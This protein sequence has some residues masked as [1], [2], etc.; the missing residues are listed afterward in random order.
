MTRYAQ[1]ISP[2]KTPQVEQAHE[3]QVENNAG[4]YSFTLDKWS[5]LDRFLILGAEGGTYYVNERKH[6]KDNYASLKECLA[7]NGPKT[8]DKIVEISV[9]GRA[10]KNDPAI[11]ALAV[12]CGAPDVPTRQ[13]AFAAIPKVCRI[14]THLFDFLTSVQEFR[15]WGRGLRRAVANWYLDKEID[16]LGFQVAKYRQRNGWTHRDVLRK[17]GGE[18]IINTEST[19]HPIFRWV[20]AGMEGMGPRAIKRGDVVKEYPAQNLGDLPKI[21]LGYEKCKTAQSA[22]EAAQIVAD[23]R[24]THEMVPSDFLKSKEVWSALL[25]SMPAMAMMRN[26]GRLTHLGLLEPFSPEIQKI[27]KVLGDG[28]VIK[29]ARLHPMESLK[30]LHQYKKGRGDKG[31][32][33]WD[34]NTKIR[35]IIEAAFYHGFDAIEPTGK[36]VV[37]AIDVSASMTWPAS[38]IAGMAGLTARE[39]AAAMAMVTARSEPNYHIQAFADRLMPVDISKTDS[40][41]SVIKKIDRLPASSTD[42]SLPVVWALEGKIPVDVFQII[43][44][45]ETWSGNIH[46]HQALELYRKQEG[47]NAKM[48]VV[49][50]TSTGFTIANPNDP[51][52][53]DVVGFDTSAPAVMADFARQGFGFGA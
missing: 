49:G 17:C 11:F 48:V 42:C 38:Q 35:E 30:A 2:R 16:Q 36:N 3:D 43:T 18:I 50:M 13:A 44:D 39:C 15:G 19:L 14:G 27:E 8:V 32:L 12:A 10:P 28:N 46:P 33:T 51:G 47:R 31:S 5:R 29:K 4:G 24:L 21:I 40:L 45:N 7:E 25:Q 37:I 20:V 22:K 6:V 9:K 34:V 1:I 53:L 23:Y 41:E 26:L 52:M